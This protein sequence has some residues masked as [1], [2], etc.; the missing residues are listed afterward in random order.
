[1]SGWGGHCKNIFAKKNI[2]YFHAKAHS[3][4]HYTLPTPRPKH[5][6]A[7]QPYDLTTK[8]QVTNATSNRQNDVQYTYQSPNRAA[9]AIRSTNRIENQ[10]QTVPLAQ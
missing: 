6:Y 2:L 7:Y 10:N 4:A 3:K 9:T 1:M 8:T 5:Q